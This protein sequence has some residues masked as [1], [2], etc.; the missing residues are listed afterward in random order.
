MS[1]RKRLSGAEFLVRV[2][3]L[4][5]RSIWKGFLKIA[6]VTCPVALYTAASTSER[7]AF[8]TVSRGSGRR[9]AR[10]FV[11]SQT[12]EVV[13][14][15][16]QIKGY[17]IG[18]GEYVMLE[19]EEIAAAVPQSDKTLAVKAF[20]GLGEVD[21]VYFDKPYFLAPSDK[22]AAANFALLRDGMLKQK[23]AAIASAVLFRRERSVLI[24]PHGDGMIAT[25]LKFDYEVRSA[26][27]AFDDIP[28]LK[29]KGEMLDLARH[30]ISMKKGKF[31]PATFED[32]YER[33]LAELVKAK[34]EGRTIEAPK[35][36]KKAQV[37]D[38]MAALRE[39]AG[40]TKTG[41]QRAKKSGAT[42]AKTTHPRKK[43]G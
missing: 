16:D 39:S 35:P 26:A 18:N 43:A 1:S 29:I 31:D 5:P 14:K 8:H 33:A 6:E 22:A 2:R 11:D 42:P 28:A 7:I 37:I 25:T 10:Q 32:H 15:D 40:A 17:E 13:E 21:D 24:R 19:P 23:S 27:G 4:A 12:G 36:R 9:V 34:L 38:L 20:L 30:I 41:A 3:V